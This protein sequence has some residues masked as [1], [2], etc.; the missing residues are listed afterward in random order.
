MV[1]STQAIHRYNLAPAGSIGYILRPGRIGVRD[2]CLSK[3][4]WCISCYAWSN[5]ISA[6]AAYVRLH[7]TCPSI[8]EQHRFHAGLDSRVLPRPTRNVCRHVKLN[9][10]LQIVLAKASPLSCRSQAGVGSGIARQLGYYAMYKLFSFWVVG[11]A[12]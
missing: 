2:V 3:T 6:P 8:K 5:H 4:S 7:R 10:V 11:S 1:T 12:M 9:P